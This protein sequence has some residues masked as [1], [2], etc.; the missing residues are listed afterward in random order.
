MVEINSRDLVDLVFGRPTNFLIC[1]IVFLASLVCILTTVLAIL[2]IVIIIVFDEICDQT[3]QKVL[4]GIV[5][6]EETLA[7]DT[8]LLK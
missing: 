5:R 3:V 7:T 4:G 6:I 2:A 1:L 8:R